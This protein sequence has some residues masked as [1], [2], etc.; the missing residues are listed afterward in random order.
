MV[1]IFHFG[2][3]GRIIE[4]FICHGSMGGG[5]VVL[6]TSHEIDYMCWM[7]GE[8]EQISRNLSMELFLI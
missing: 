6:D 1:F 3:L 7:A 5:G 4:I 2:I 8:I